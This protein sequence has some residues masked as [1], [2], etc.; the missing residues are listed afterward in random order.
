MTQEAYRTPQGFTRRGDPDGLG[1]RA[2]LGFALLVGFVAFQLAL[3][4]AVHV[5]TAQHATAATVT[6]GASITAQP[7]EEGNNDSTPAT[8]PDTAQSYWT[9]DDTVDASEAYVTA[10]SYWTYDDSVDASEAYER[11]LEPHDNS[12]ACNL[13]LGIDINC[14]FD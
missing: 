1:V 2:K 13:G 12:R 10:Q 5:L 7:A 6:T 11:Y 3:A 14:I 8:R 4:G 9:Y